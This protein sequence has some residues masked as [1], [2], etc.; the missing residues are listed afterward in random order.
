[1][2]SSSV[3]SS[4]GAA[5]GQAPGGAPPSNQV[6]KDDFLRLLMA[7]MSQQDPSSPMD[8]QAF[9][10][11]LATLASVEQLQGANARLE[12]MLVAQA[13]N[14][15]LQTAGL[16]GKDVTYATDA[17]ELAVAGDQATVG[18]RLEADADAVTV[19]VKDAR[20]N[21]VRTL[22]SGN[23]DAGIG[24]VKWDGM[25]DDGKPVPAGAYSVQVTASKNGNNVAAEACRTRRV[26]AVS[27]AGGFPQLVV[28]D[29]TLNLADVLEV[30]AP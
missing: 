4:L 23:M 20:G 9:V 7:G 29:T 3:V 21:V 25:D 13:A 22:R 16:V 14:N 8:A 12:S 18:V 17:V 10:A 19:V 6:G 11:Q 2:S 27:Y 28:G 1:M 24:S 15:Q 5:A 26:D 30:R